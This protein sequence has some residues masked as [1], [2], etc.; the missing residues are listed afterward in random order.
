[1]MSAFRYCGTGRRSRH[2]CSLLKSLR[3][4]T[5]REITQA[6]SR[7]WWS[8]YSSGHPVA[9]DA[10][11]SRSRLLRGHSRIIA[12]A[13]QEQENKTVV[14]SNRGRCRTS[15]STRRILHIAC[16]YPSI[17][18]SPEQLRGLTS[19]RNRARERSYTALG[20]C[21]VS[22]VI[23]VPHIYVSAGSNRRDLETCNPYT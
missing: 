21:V 17:H 9:C 3:A 1:M 13:A 2:A 7:I 12:D 4:A 23:L 8:G 16:M 14:A 10:A 18:P 6:C 22:I 20:S 5:L 15:P 11:A 19:A